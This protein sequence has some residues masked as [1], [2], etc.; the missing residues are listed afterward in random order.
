MFGDEMGYKAERLVQLNSDYKG[1]D[2]SVYIL[3]EM[4]ELTKEIIKDLRGKGNK[5][6]IEEEMADVLCTILTYAI[7][8]D[9][10]IHGLEDIVNKK[11]DRGID[12]ALKMEF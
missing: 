7:Y 2:Q 10:D 9:I 6:R 4:A 12:R 11:I 3:E 8:K 5:E 1:I